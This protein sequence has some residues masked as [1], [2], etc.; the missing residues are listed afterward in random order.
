MYIFNDVWFIIYYNYNFE[1]CLKIII[2][3]D[4][5]LHKEFL[6]PCFL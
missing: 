1:P 5:S 6:L 2:F 3:V 4:E